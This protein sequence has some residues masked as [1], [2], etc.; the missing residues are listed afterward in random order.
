MRRTRQFTTA[1]VLTALVATGIGSAITY[2]T[3]EANWSFAADARPAIGNPPAEGLAHARGL[4]DAFKYAAQA[5]RP[6]V[7]SIRSTKVF[8]PAVE[9]FERNGERGRPQ[10]RP[11]LPEEFREFFGD[12]FFDRFGAEP[13]GDQ[14]QIPGSPN[15]PFRQEGQGTGVIVSKM[16]SRSLSRMIASIAPR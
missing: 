9:R 8:K 13:F 3:R 14:F 15:R 16:R 7:V 1:L 5:I 10:T 2:A 6:S 12:D 4:S 11:E